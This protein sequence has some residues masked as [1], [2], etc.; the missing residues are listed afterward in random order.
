MLGPKAF[1]VKEVEGASHGLESELV[2]V[3]VQRREGDGIGAFLR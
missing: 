1:G 3:D 2:L